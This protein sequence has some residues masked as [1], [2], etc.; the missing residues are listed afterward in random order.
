M[1]AKKPPPKAVKPPA[2]PD[3]QN[4][5]LLKLVEKA[6]RKEVTNI[7]RK[8]DSGKTLNAQERQLLATYA[9]PKPAPTPAK[10]QARRRRPTKVD[11]DAKKSASLKYPPPDGLSDRQRK[12]WVEIT[13]YLPASHFQY[14]D[15][16]MLRQ[17]VVLAT[18]LDR[19]LEEWDGS[20][21]IIKG[22]GDPAVN[23]VQTAIAK[24][25]ASVS[26]LAGKL[27]I[28]PSSRISPQKAGFEKEIPDDSKWEGLLS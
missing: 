19:Q 26:A 13:K 7:L 28:C 3:L 10:K 4:D 9:E 18:Q 16:P 23:P 6:K 11:D 22:N 1:T 15:L 8:L 17:Y 5:P 27:R 24:M 21:T 2:E 25:T 14:S 12:L 20:P